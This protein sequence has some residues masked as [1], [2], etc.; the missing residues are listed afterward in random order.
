MVRIE[1]GG[2]RLAVL[3]DADNASAQHLEQLLVEIAKY[4]K[5]SVRRAY[6]DWT[7]TR[8]TSWKAELLRHSVQPIQQFSYTI[9]KN[10]TDSALIIDAM[11]LLHAGNLDGFC[12]VSSD[13]DFTR[14][15][16]RVREQGLIVYGFGERKTPKP[17]VAACDTFIYVENLATDT[18][19]AKSQAKPALKRDH[20][21]D[22]LLAEAVE[23]AAG[24]DGW[25]HLGAVGSNL[26]RLAS[27]FD[28]RT[29]GFT[30][31]KDLMDAHP[32][33]QIQSRPTGEGKTPNAFVRHK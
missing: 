26:S 11:D 7:S 1:S 21:L 19:E 18:I 23:V 20:K 29:W 6:G 14:L 16:A 2:A 17:F 5:A 4:G 15:A 3:V 10:A 30:K 31:L 24:D 25:A 22:R 12:L 13:S 32:D 9:G 27:D 8:L 33:F 28:S